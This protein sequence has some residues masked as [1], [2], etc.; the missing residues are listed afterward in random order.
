MDGTHEEDA[1]DE[2]GDGEDE[3]EEEQDREHKEGTRTRERTSTGKRSWARSTLAREDE[4][5]RQRSQRGQLEA[6]RTSVCG[7]TRTRT[8]AGNAGKLLTYF[9]HL[10]QD[11][12]RKVVAITR[13]CSLVVLCSCC[14]LYA[15]IC[16]FSEMLPPAIPPAS[17]LQR[18][19][20]A[21]AHGPRLERRRARARRSRRRVRTL[22]PSRPRRSQ[23]VD[24]LENGAEGAGCVG[25]FAHKSLCVWVGG[26][27]TRGSQIGHALL[28][29]SPP[30][31]GLRRKCG[32]PALL[33]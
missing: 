29:R 15:Y 27:R 17:L 20:L 23:R 9:H 26:S 7:W 30:T 21:R 10:A 18:L 14:H 32:Q 4:D 1:G 22:P 13:L 28:E 19:L 6:K 11:S 2:E 5:D 8:G 12:V 3:D 31:L 24:A 33:R 25:A 16:F